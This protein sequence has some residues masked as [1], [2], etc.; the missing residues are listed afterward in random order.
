MGVLKIHS[1]YETLKKKIA[2]L[3]SAELI[4]SENNLP[5]FIADNLDTYKILLVGS[6][7]TIR[8]FIDTFELTDSRFV[9]LKADARIFSTKQS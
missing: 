5:A 2:R 6:A 7:F 4:Q 1:S 8:N 9:H 3:A